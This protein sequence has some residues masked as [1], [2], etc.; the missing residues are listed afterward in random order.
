LGVEIGGGFF[1]RPDDDVRGEKA[2]QAAVKTLQRNGNGSL[3]VRNLTQRVHAGIGPA[4]ADQPHTLPGHPGEV[5]L[6][7]LLNGDSIGLDLP[8]VIIRAII[9]NE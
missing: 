8:P 3:K 6:E 5:L 7:D 1:Y 4:G 9:L 2:V